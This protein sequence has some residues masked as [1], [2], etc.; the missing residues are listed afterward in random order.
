M[1]SIPHFG[2][3]T[4]AYPGQLSFL[5]LLN[6]LPYFCQLSKTTGMFTATRKNKKLYYEIMQQLYYSKQLSSVELSTLLNKS[7][8]LITRALNFLIESGFVMEQGYAASSGGRRPLMYALNAEKL[9]IVTVAMDQL[10]TRIGIVD[11]LN[12]YVSAVEITSLKLPH[13]P[14]A[15][16]T[17]SNLINAYIKKSGI[18]KNNILGIG[19]GMP[20]FVNVVEGINL[21]YLHSGDQSLTAYLTNATGIPVFIDND[22]SLIAL[23]ELKFGLAKEIKNAMVINLSWGIGLGM[24]INGQLF[25]GD[26][27]FAGEFSHIPLTEDGKLCACGKQGCLESEAS[28]LAIAEK[29]VLEVQKG[30]KTNLPYHADL[31]LMEV[32][33][34]LMD[35]ANEGDQ[36][37]IEL[38]SESA[39]KIGRGLSILIHIMNPKTIIISGRGVKIGELLLAPIHQALN[40][41]CIPRLS[42]G[43]DIQ[44]SQIG[45]DAELLG[46]AILVMESLG[47][48]PD[49]Q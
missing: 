34:A 41:Y 3:D 20:G 21:T 42:K 19:I 12:N 5:I 47:N 18:E 37:A 31:S 33:E 11:L 22:S 9:Y 43:T 16:K 44:L 13:N 17:L 45:F 25:R 10:S 48:T 2:H 27:G 35:V 30:R 32:G 1:I 29:A 39:Y 24:I 36:F 8:P 38:L 28:L 7:N 40:K 4:A 14:A 49:Q 6:R 26:S 23:S 46:A 15:L